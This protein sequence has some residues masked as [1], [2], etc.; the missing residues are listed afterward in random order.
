MKRIV[1]S[2]FIF[3]LALA[4]PAA[5][6]LAPKSV[7][8]GIDVKVKDGMG[9]QF[10]EGLKKFRQWQQQQNYPFTEHAWSIITGERGGHYVFVTGGHDWKDF[11][12]TEKFGPGSW[13]EIQADFAPYVASAV[14]SFWQAHP[15]L[16]S[17]PQPGEAPPKFL[18][19]VTYSLKVGAEDDFEDVIKQAGAA[20]EKTHWPGGHA[21]WYSLLNGGEGPQWVLV[22]GHKSWADFQPPETPFGKMLSSVYGKEGA[23]ALGKKFAKSVR[24]VHTEILRSRPELGY[25]PK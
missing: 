21:G 9:Q 17:P 8:R 24:S 19:F 11:D 25:T 4:L 10:E 20:I 12:E 7:S 18:T 6:Q 3:V 22:I 15:S 1:V 16:G 5:A 2:L 14:F 23:E 13:K